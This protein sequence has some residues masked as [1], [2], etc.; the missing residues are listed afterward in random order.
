MTDVAKWLA[1]ITYNKLLARYYY[2][3]FAVYL[4]VPGVSPNVHYHERCRSLMLGGV[5][6]A[7]TQTGPVRHSTCTSAANHEY[8]NVLID[9]IYQQNSL[10]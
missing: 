7:H 3:A 4:T 1:I 2:A 5:C 8:G 10:M 6:S 9:S